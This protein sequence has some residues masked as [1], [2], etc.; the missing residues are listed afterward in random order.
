MWIW[1]CLKKSFKKNYDQ[2]VVAVAAHKGATAVSCG[3]GAGVTHQAPISLGEQRGGK[4]TCQWQKGV[5]KYKS[6]K[7][8]VHL[9]LLLS[10]SAERHHM[11]LSCIWDW[12][13]DLWSFIVPY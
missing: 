2:I 9:V 13:F 1:A 8:L 3:V 11:L 7:K 6:R 4:H 10:K 12:I 5:H